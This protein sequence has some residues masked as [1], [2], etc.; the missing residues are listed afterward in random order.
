MANCIGQTKTVVGKKK[1]RR[2]NG[3]FYARRRIKACNIATVSK[4][5]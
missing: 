2:R 5:K 4:K 1:L 3:V